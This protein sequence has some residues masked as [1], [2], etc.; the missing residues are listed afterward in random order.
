MLGKPEFLIGLI[1]GLLLATVLISALFRR[2]RS[3]QD[4]IQ[5]PSILEI[6]LKRA[7]RLEY[8]LALLLFKARAKNSN[9]LQKWLTVLRKDLKLRKY[10]LI[11]HWTSNDLLAVLPGTNLDSSQEKGLRYRFDRLMIEGGWSNI[12]YGIAIFPQHGEEIRDL[13]GYARNHYRKP[14]VRSMNND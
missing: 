10:D 2:R 1:S 7:Q 8:Q 5:A 13:V 14:S 9:D 12:S 3:R 6:E 11:L 4:S